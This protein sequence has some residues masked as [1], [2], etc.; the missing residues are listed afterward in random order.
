MDEQVDHGDILYQ[1]EVE[2]FDWDTSKSIY[3]RVLEAEFSLF[4]DNLEN[5]IRGEYNHIKMP[6]K[7]NYNSITD[8]NSLLEIDM[9]RSLTM[10][11]SIDYLR[12]MTHPPYKNAYFL[13]DKGE[14]VFV[15]LD[16]KKDKIAIIE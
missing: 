1:K 12:A 5:L 11:Q 15:A 14:K 9:D 10:R 8:F 16:I 3:D 6:I 2:V 7:G 4:E 13:T